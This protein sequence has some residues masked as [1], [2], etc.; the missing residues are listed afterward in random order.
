LDDSLKSEFKKNQLSTL[1]KDGLRREILSELE[2]Q[3]VE[4]E[5]MKLM[6]IDQMRKK[7]EMENARLVTSN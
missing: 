1:D 6:E 3:K 7:Y 5:A 2:K 4:L